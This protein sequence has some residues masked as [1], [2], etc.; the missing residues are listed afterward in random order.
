MSDV[1]TPW[2][3]LALPK[4]GNTLEQPHPL[5][6]DVPRRFWR[7]WHYAVLIRCEPTENW[8]D[9]LPA[10]PR[11]HQWAVR[12]HLAWAARN[13]IDA[14]PIAAEVA[15]WRA[16]TNAHNRAIARAKLRRRAT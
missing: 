3:R 7:P 12:D 8:R 1:Q 10:V 4:I 2:D 11:Q 5:D 16:D 15:R 14:G 13:K 6:P 9:L